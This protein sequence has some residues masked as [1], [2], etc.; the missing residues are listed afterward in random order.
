MSMIKDAIRKKRKSK[1]PTTDF[2]L[3]SQNCLGGVLYSDYDLPFNSPTINMFIEGEGFCK[4]VERLDY[5]LSVEPLPVMEEYVDPIDP[6]ISYPLIRIDDVVLSCMHYDSCQ[7]AIDAWN[8]R[9]Q[10]CDLENNKVIVLANSWNMHQDKELVERVCS[11][12]YPTVCFTV[13]EKIS[14]D[15]CINCES[16]IQLDSRGV[17]RPNLTDRKK[18]SF[19]KVYEDFFDFPAWLRSELG[20]DSDR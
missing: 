16:E 7:S 11:S 4:L 13:G 3:I 14:G 15:R 6:S 12:P 8:R 9:R 1:L 10:R 20:F 19:R 2:V 18:L 5:Y 17:G